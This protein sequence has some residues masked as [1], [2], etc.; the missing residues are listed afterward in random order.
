MV[1]SASTFVVL[2]RR[3]VA[4]KNLIVEEDEALQ[5]LTI[6]V[7]VSKFGFQRA[8]RVFVDRCVRGSSIFERAI[9]KN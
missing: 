5:V 1:V 3:G 8:D 4:L 9:A 2:S 6:A 7:S